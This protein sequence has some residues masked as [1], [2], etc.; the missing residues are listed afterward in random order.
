MGSLSVP[1]ILVS[2]YIAL[3]IRSERRIA[4]S[5]Q[6]PLP[7]PRTSETDFGIPWTFEYLMFSFIQS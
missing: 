5:S 7:L 3:W 2:A 1:I 6:S 4:C